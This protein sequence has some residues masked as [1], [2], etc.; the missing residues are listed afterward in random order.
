MA[1]ADWIERDSAR[2]EI[3][4][5]VFIVT[6]SALLLYAVLKPYLKPATEVRTRL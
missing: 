3:V 4:V 6:T 2:D 1:D 5:I